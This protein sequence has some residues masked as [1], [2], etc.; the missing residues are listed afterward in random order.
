MQK[1]NKYS[2]IFRP[3]KLGNFSP[4]K[5]LF[6]SKPLQ[7]PK[8]YEINDEIHNWKYFYNKLGNLL[9]SAEHMNI[10]ETFLIKFLDLFYMYIIEK[11]PYKDF[12]R[13]FFFGNYTKDRYYFYYFHDRIKIIEKGIPDIYSK[14]KVL[15]MDDVI[16]ETYIDLIEK[17]SLLEI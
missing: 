6:K 15:Y 2:T 8:I 7:L 4:N 9:I 1:I 12:D 10:Q 5:K 13:R 3:E 17:S 11:Y 14:I 16:F